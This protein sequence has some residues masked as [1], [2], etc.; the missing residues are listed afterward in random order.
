MV[1]K[2]YPSK[3]W[4]LMFIA[5]FIAFIALFIAV[6][7]DSADSA[8]TVDNK[9]YYSSPMMLSTWHSISRVFLSPNFHYYSLWV[10]AVIVEKMIDSIVVA[11]FVVLITM[12]FLCYFDYFVLI[13]HR[14]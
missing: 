9:H 7:D 2:L 3:F 10:V 1:H 13:S 5:L 4:Y 11:I 6:S 8:D 12:D 14:L